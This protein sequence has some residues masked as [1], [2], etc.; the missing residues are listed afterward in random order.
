MTLAKSKN[1]W[2]GGAAVR[3]FLARSRVRVTHPAITIT[4]ADIES[5]RVLLKLELVKVDLTDVGPQVRAR[6]L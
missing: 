5:G 4:R 6:L 1:M 3:N 2:F